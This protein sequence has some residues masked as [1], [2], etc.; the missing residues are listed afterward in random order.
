MKLINSFQG[1]NRWLSNFWLCEIEW[2]GLLYPSVEHAY[3]ASKTLDLEWRKRISS[4]QNS[5][6]AKKIGRLSKIRDNWE[7]IKQKIMEELI[8]K[9]FQIPELKQKLLNTEDAELI[10]GNNWGDT[11]WGICNGVG[12]NHLGRLLMKTRHFIKNSL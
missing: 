1:K 3:Q 10:E 7:E 5:R 8:I 12:E 11:Y 9:K 6:K 4:L 2:E